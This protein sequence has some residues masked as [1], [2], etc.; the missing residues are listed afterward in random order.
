[1]NKRYEKY[2]D[3]FEQIKNV[4][5]QALIENHLTS[6]INYEK[7]NN[8][9]FVSKCENVIKEFPEFQKLTYLI[10]SICLNQFPQKC[11]NKSCN[12]YLN[13]GATYMSRYKYCCFSC[14]HKSEEV[15]EKYKQTMPK[16]FF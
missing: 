12:N 15:Q 9:E 5:N 4:F 2:E 11:K 1:M 14:A 16:T 10:K 7:K 8:V 3:L 6:K 13:Y